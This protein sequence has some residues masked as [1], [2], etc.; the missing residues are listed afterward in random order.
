MDAGELA[1]LLDTDSFR[2]KFVSEAL[3]LSRATPL[4]QT[5]TESTPTL[6]I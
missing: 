1:E 3:K 6:E 5:I 2:S 4:D